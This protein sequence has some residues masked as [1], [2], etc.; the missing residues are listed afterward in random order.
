[1][2]ATQV[3]DPLIIWKLVWIQS[4]KAFLVPY[5]SVEAL[6]LPNIALSGCFRQTVGVLLAHDRS[7]ELPLADWQYTQYRHLTT[8]M[9]D[10]NSCYA[11][12]ELNDHAL[13]RLFEDGSINILE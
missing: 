10:S 9:A 2:H 7:F 3:V 1:M 4:L 11:V 13:S 6:E 8:K 12:N 5:D